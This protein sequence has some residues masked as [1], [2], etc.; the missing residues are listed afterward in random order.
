LNPGGV[1]SSIRGG[2]GPA[3]VDEAAA[4]L[5]AI[6]DEER[7]EVLTIY[8]DIGGYGHPD[9]IQVHRVGVRAAELAGTPMV[10][11]ATINRDHLLRVRDLAPDPSMDFDPSGPM[12]DGN[13]LGS[14]EAEINL[15]VDVTPFLEQ[16]RQALA[17]H[18]SQVTDIG[19]FLAMPRDVFDAFFGTEWF[20][21][22]GSDAPMHAGWLLDEVG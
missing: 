19:M 11:E 8:D 4:R 5:A 1:T 18:A 2:A 3:D 7:A 14:L 12:D 13:P 9:H 22:P 21:E 10:Y 20:I 6:L 17:A 15:A 16:K